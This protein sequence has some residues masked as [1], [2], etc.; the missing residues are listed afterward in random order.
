M[1]ENLFA[2]RGLSLE[3]LR[4][5]L[6]VVEA[7]SIVRAVDGDPV[8]Q[9][10]YSR[11]ISELE[12][13]FGVDL[14]RRRGK[15]L[16]PTSDGCV[17]ASSARIQ[18]QGLDDFLNVCECQLQMFRLG[19]GDSL[20]QWVV[21]PIL[22]GF[23]RQ[24]PRTQI[25]LA[26]LRS[27]DIVEQLNEL[28]IDFGLARKNIIRK[29]LKSVLIGVVSYGLFIPKKLLAERKRGK[30]IGDRALLENLPWATLGSD[31]E[32]M[33]L[34]S[35]ACTEH[36]IVPN[37]KLITQSFPQAARAIRS[38]EFAAILPMHSRSTFNTNEFLVRETPLLKTCDRKVSLA[39]NPK[40]LAFRPGA[41]HALDY[42]KDKLKI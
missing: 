36:G 39:W 2:K 29:P 35:L 40:T 30:S 37:F 10:Q 17:L 33:R 11:Q 41:E 20:L 5:F 22:S 19:A 13:F 1:F 27:P 7:G 38:H 32:F 25:S 8:R 42:L 4:S 16:E 23:Q 34:V 14:V 3:R 6:E 9:S 26:N 31:G 28:R 21:L 24:F 18:L 15:R 12:A